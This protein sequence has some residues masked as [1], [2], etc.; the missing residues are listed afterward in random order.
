MAERLTKCKSC[1]STDV[2]TVS[3]VNPDTHDMNCDAMLRCNTCKCVF[4][5]LVASPR[6]YRDR[7]EGWLI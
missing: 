3:L 1:G 6:Y 2:E 5:G 7:E 4:N